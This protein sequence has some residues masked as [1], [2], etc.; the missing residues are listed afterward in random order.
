[1]LVC[2]AFVHVGLFKEHDYLQLLI[3]LVARLDWRQTIND[4]LESFDSGKARQRDLKER[5]RKNL[6][7]MEPPVKWTVGNERQF[8]SYLKKLSCEPKS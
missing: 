6:E 8:Y 3:H 1:M 2:L 4:A 7:A 5:V